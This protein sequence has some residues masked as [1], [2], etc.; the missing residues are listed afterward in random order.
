MNWLSAAEGALS[1]WA[2]A[3]PAASA[4]VVNESG[5]L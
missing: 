2:N 4:S 3:T 5:K 1:D